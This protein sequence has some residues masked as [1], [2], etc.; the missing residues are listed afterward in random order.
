[1]KEIFLEL[2]Q[3]SSFAL[4]ALA[5]ECQHHLSQDILFIVE[6]HQNLRKIFKD[7]TLKHDLCIVNALL[8]SL[9]S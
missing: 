4:W 7:K 6:F 9:L 1:V 3:Y 8:I 2:D 5:C